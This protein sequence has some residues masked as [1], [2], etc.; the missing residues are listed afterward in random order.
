MRAD[1][2]TIVCALLAAALLAFAVPSFGGAAA[3]GPERGETVLLKRDSGIVEFKTPGADAFMELHGS[4]L[5]PV[6]TLVDTR[7]GAVHVT[8]SR[9]GG[10]TDTGRF[11]DGLFEVRQADAHGAHTTA[12]LRGKVSRSCSAD[13]R[14]KRELKAHAHS[15]FKTVGR[16]SSAAAFGTQWLTKDTCS[17]TT[18]AVKSGGGVVVRD[19]GTHERIVL[20]AGESYKAT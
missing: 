13:H 17:T 14:R 2:K 19:F 20:H 12:V 7:D 15:P 10:K 1:R 18:T 3:S 4:E 16:R 8:S 9:G 5:V 11:W 6:K